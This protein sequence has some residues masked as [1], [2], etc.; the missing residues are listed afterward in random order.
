MLHQFSPMNSTVKLL[1]RGGRGET[2]LL[3]E[4]DLK[5]D[6]AKNKA[7]EISSPKFCHQLS[8]RKINLDLSQIKRRL[9]HNMDNF[10]GI[11]IRLSLQAIRV[12]LTA[13]SSTPR[14]YNRLSSVCKFQISNLKW[15]I[16]HPNETLS[17][18][19]EFF[20][21]LPSESVWTV[22]VRWYAN[23]ITKFSRTHR[24]PQFSLGLRFRSDGPLFIFDPS[25]YASDSARK[26]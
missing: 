3:L 22:G 25:A 16:L 23:V 21:H 18:P 6:Q 13:L 20:I 12:L 7:L 10:I 14:K 19:T 26:L 15:L 4:R 5:R 2:R 9:I 24:F 8:T 11:I 1:S 17:Y